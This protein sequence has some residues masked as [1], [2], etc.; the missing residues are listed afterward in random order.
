[1]AIDFQDSSSQVRATE[2]AGMIKAATA[3]STARSTARSTATPF[4][5]WTSIKST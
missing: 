1:M 4:V 2:A 3:N 5:A